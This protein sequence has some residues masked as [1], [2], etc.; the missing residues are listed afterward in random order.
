MSGDRGPTVRETVDIFV[1][2]IADGSIRDRSG[3]IYK[4]ST[5]RGYQ[6]E[7]RGRVVEAFGGSRLRE[8]TLPDTQRWADG[9]AACGLAPATVRNVVTAL[10]ALYGWALPRGMA[11]VNPTVGLRLPT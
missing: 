9:L 7:L 5:R 3:R 2:G 6:R 11:T 10:R 8:L 1:A 4:P